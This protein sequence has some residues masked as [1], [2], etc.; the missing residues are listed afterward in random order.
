M[1]AF[2][3]DMK[4]WMAAMENQQKLQQHSVIELEQDDENFGDRRNEVP[5]VI[6][7]S[8]E[9]FP[10][11]DE[12]N[13]R[14]WVR[15]CN[16]YFQMHRIP[17]NSKMDYVALHVKGKIDDWF[18][19]YMWDDH[20]GMVSWAEFSV[21]ICRRFNLRKT[22]MEEEE[23]FKLCKQVHGV[24]KYTKDTEE[25][26]EQKLC[27][28][29][30][31]KWQHAHNA[32]LGIK[33]IEEE[34][35]EDPETREETAEISLDEKLEGMSIDTLKLL[36]RVNKKSIMILIDTGS[37]HS[38]L[39]PEIVQ[40]M[41]LKCAQTSPVQVTVANGDEMIC[42]VV[43]PKF[44]WTV[45]GETF[46]KDMMLLKMNGCMCDMVLGMDW[47]DEFAPV[48]MD[49]KPLS[50]SFHKG[51]RWETLYGILPGSVLKKQSK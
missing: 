1:A 2:R 32:I 42:D 9:K 8:E 10:D 14:G 35:E 49:T 44:K 20:G 31:E 38:F 39:N 40:D 27:F 48:Q 30:K 22:S 43:C 21:D 25:L 3:S 5:V 24:E 41:G 13:P 12:G 46:E 11:L 33:E 45:Q 34:G 18:E 17:E 29:C 7:N 6:C 37:T 36:G 47:V 4:Q 15:S 23:E 50:I 51:S 28:F 16:K 19:G 26:K